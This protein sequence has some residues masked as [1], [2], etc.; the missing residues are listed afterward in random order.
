MELETPKKNVAD[1][2]GM[3]GSWM[4]WDALP[5]TQ[6]IHFPWRKKP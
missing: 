1:F 3:I 5:I 6:D 2:E 4:E